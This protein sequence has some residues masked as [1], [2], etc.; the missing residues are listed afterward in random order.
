MIAT[1]HTA[2]VES[3]AP[4][5]DLLQHVLTCSGIQAKQDIAKVSDGLPDLPPDW[6]ANGDDTAAIPLGDNAEAG[7][8]L[9][10]I[11]GMQGQF[12]NDQPW[13]AGWC[14]VMVNCSDI[15]AMGGRPTAVVNAIWCKEADK[16]QRQEM[17]RGMRD[18]SKRL[19]IPIAGGHTN[20]RADG[21]NLSV[22]ILGHANR[23]LTSF[24][25]QPG[26]KLIAAMDL[27]GTFH[28]TSLNWDAATSSPPYRMRDDLALLPTL[29]E[30]QLAF[31]CKD[32]SQAGLLGTCLMLLESSACGAN[33]DL[34]AIPKPSNVHLRD[35]LC[36]FPSFGYLLTTD[37]AHVH[38][39]LNHF[40]K[41]DISAAVIGHITD[42]QQLWVSQQRET[43][44][45]F[46]IGTRGLTGFSNKAH[47]LSTL[48][49]CAPAQPRPERSCPP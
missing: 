26:Q 31:A 24:A 7:Y 47:V 1:D 28:G 16:A 2:S 42:T 17:L 39:L 29:S 25:A 11:E 43:R 3:N 32:I 4:L 23:L 38:E 12:V 5:D 27:R 41:R 14:G 30:K 21:N 19:G 37:D 48:S 9:F 10:A 45:F 8:Q 15:A 20:L 44:Q 18:A 40:H 36:A 13:F 35:W 33:I 49:Q 46:D 34:D 22:A 6:L